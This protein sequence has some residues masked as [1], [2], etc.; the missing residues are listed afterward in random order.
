MFENWNM[1]KVV[2][3]IVATMFI[4][5]GIGFGILASTSGGAVN[6]LNTAFSGGRFEVN[7]EKISQGNAIT[8]INIEASSADIIIIPE[9]RSDVKAQL[10]GRVSSADIEPKLEMTL[11]NDKL[12]ISAKNK[13]V[14]VGINVSSNLQL[15]VYVPKGYEHSIKASTAS[16]DISIKDFKLKEFICNVASG[17]LTI[18]N[19]TS[20]NISCTSASGSLEGDNIIS[21]TTSFKIVSGHVKLQK[22]KGELKGTSTSGKI[23]VS[24]TEFDNDINLS[25]TSGDVKIS[26]PKTSEFYLDARTTSGHI[27]CDFPITISE[28]KKNNVLCGTVK[29]GTNKINIHVTSGD[30]NID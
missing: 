28:N 30:I 7:Q 9:D 27:R 10:T 23:N 18:N 5:F 17:D 22:F 26:L 4:S 6:L 25:S 13:N 24:Y 2:L 1:K 15:K 11:E 20:E 21:K 16:G 12:V 19:I 3:Y 14:I 8:A 29:S